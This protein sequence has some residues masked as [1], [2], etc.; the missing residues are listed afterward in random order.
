MKTNKK[1]EWC[2]ITVPSKWNGIS[3]EF[4]LREI[5]CV[6]KKDI[7]STSNGKKCYCK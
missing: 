7:T 3:I 1:G 5:W 2:E 6:P 4:L